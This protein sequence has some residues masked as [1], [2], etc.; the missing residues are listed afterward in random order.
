MK[1]YSIEN[2]LTMAKGKK[3]LSPKYT[4][5]KNTTNIKQ[6]NPS[7]AFS[8]QN[9]LVETKK[10]KKTRGLQALM[11]G[12]CATLF[13]LS[14]IG[15]FFMPIQKQSNQKLNNDEDIKPAIVETYTTFDDFDENEADDIE[16]IETKSDNS[17][18]D[19]R[20]RDL[21]VTTN[22]IYASKIFE[23]SGLSEMD[24]NKFCPPM[25]DG[26]ASD[27]SYV[28][29]PSDFIEIEQDKNSIAYIVDHDE[30]FQNGV[31][32]GMGNYI[33]KICEKYDL[34]SN[35]QKFLCVSIMANECG[36][37]TTSTVVNHNNPGGFMDSETDYS[38][39]KHF[40][41]LENGI[42]AV[43]RNLANN[44]IYNDRD[45]IAL[46][47]EKYAPV[48]ALNDPNDLN[49]NWAKSVRNIYNDLTGEDISI[50]DKIA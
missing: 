21:I 19:E 9:Y 33:E 39:V 31:L 42:E 30:R 48:G 4:N 1:I 2:S 46:I 14:Q 23:N 10:G 5:S 36:F 8:Q 25:T 34:M 50:N 27:E 32:K 11:A 47:G 38:T 41:T 13:S 15:G 18:A 28:E 49:S 24:S 29:N 44:Y 16:L 43:I 22:A 20:Q 37:G 12:A 3:N 26:Y 17:E 35:S 40:D 7:D 6:Q 45:T